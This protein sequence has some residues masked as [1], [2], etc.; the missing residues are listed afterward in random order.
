MVHHK[1]REGKDMIVKDD[2]MFEFKEIVGFK[3][4]GGVKLEVFLPDFFLTKL[5]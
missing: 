2:Y 5:F 1:K 4:I 3:H